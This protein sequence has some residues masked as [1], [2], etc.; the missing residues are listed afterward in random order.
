[1]KIVIKTKNLELNQELQDYIQEKINSLEKFAKVFQG[2][3]YYNG[4]FTK[5]KPRAEVWVEIGR[6]TKHHQKGDIFRAEVQMRLSGKSLRAESE[7]NDLKLAITEIKD[8]LQR[9]LKK[10]K[11][12]REV[13]RPNT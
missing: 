1:M 2:E 7:R 6:T 12:K 9:E 10:Y 13:W 11:G 8:E 3:N 5:G 4:F